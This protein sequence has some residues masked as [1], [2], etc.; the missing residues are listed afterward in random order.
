[1]CCQHASGSLKLERRTCAVYGNL[2]AYCS[3]MPRMGLPRR[4][5]REMLSKWRV[6]PMQQ[7]YPPGYSD[8]RSG[9]SD[10]RYSDNAL[11][12]AWMSA[13]DPSRR[14]FWRRI[15]D[16]W[17]HLAS[18][19]WQRPAHSLEER[20]RT[21]RS[22]LAAWIILGFLIFALILVPLGLGDPSTLISVV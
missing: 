12:A 17:L 15:G 21:R 3:S 7:P 13:E 14:G 11:S 8:P 16:A 10:P 2:V 22:R 9:Y 4:G 5:S 18:S 20:E 19:G 6:K 1:V